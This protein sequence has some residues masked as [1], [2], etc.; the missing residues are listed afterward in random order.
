MPARTRAGAAE[1]GYG[2]G[3][4]G[5]DFT[6]THFVTAHTGSAHVE[7]AFTGTAYTGTAHAGAGPAYT[8]MGMAHTGTGHAGAAHAPAAAAGPISGL[9][10]GSAFILIAVVVVIIAAI[11]VVPL[12]IDVRRATAWRQQITE[13]LLDDA[14]H[15]H[16]VRDFLRDLREPRGVRGLTRSVIAVV[17]LALV[18]F[19]LAVA[20]FSSGADSGDLRKTIVTSLMTVLATVAGFYFGSLGAQNSAEDARRQ[21]VRVPSAPKAAAAKP[22]AAPVADPPAG[23]HGA[24][25]A[26]ARPTSPA[27]AAAP[28]PDPSAAP[29][30]DA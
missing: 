20:M 8:G 29:E 9:D 26:G 13:R 25:P 30:R 3:T 12:I 5:N 24:A 16:D 21:V 18:G 15:D 22:P 17:I 2:A 10:G 14:A 23:P 19:A 4:G 28:A 11:A 7:A 1:P 27:T 6:M